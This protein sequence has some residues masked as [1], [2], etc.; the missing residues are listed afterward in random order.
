MDEC[1]IPVANRSI[2]LHA[3]D[4]ACDFK[5]VTNFRAGF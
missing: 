2:K 5:K 3:A 4:L 1:A